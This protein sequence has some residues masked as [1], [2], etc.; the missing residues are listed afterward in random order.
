MSASKSMD[1]LRTV[2]RSLGANKQIFTNPMIYEALGAGTEDQPRRDRIRK[3][4][5]QLIRTGEL[6][7]VGRGEYQYI[8]E[9]EPR[10]DTPFL[11]RA[12]RAL[13]AARPGFSAFDISRRAGV[14]YNYICIWFR[15]LESEGFIK[16][17]GREQNTILY[18]ATSKTQQTRETPVPEKESRDPFETERAALCDLVRLF[19]ISNPYQP[20]TQKKILK[21]CRT[22]LARFEKQEDGI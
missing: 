15:H 4:C 17:H 12:W 21:N 9:A 13:K 14:S 11:H 2:C 8:K 22:I 7:R 19:M 16:Q 10:R 20:G 6:K 18:R 5:T 1:D 3:R